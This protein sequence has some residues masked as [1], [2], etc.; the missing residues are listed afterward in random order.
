MSASVIMAVE[1]I[2]QRNI[3]EA[4]ERERRAKDDNDPVVKLHGDDGRRYHKSMAC[5]CRSHANG[6]FAVLEELA[7]HDPKLR[8]EVSRLRPKWHMVLV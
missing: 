5:S 7:K 1:L 3:V 8:S 6:A 4:D 2:I